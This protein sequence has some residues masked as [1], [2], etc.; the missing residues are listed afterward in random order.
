LLPEPVH[1]DECPLYDAGKH[2]HVAIAGPPQNAWACLRDTHGLEDPAPGPRP[3]AEKAQLRQRTI[4]A[5]MAAQP[6]LTTLLDRVEQAGLA[7]GRVE[8]L[9]EVL[10]G[11]V[12]RQQGLLAHVDDRR[13]G[14]RPIVR[15]P[16]RFDGERRPVPSPAPRRGEHNREVLEELLGYDGE[17][18]AALS[19]AGVLHQAAPDAR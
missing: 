8:A 19:E 2:G 1:R 10:L 6:D 3:R 9:R 7:G 18:I 11:P 15:T 12:S 5:W 4:E 13:G 16:Y 17:R 14:T